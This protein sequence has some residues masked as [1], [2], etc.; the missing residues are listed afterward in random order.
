MRSRLLP[1]P[2]PPAM[3]PMSDQPAIVRALTAVDAAPLRA[4]R[5]E[6]LRAFPPAFAASVEEDEARSIDDFAR[7]L[8][9]PD[10]MAVYGA[11]AG[12]ELVGM[13]GFHRES[14]LKMRHK[15]TLWGVYVRA[16]R[17]GQGLG[18]RLVQAVIDHARGRVERLQ[19]CVSTTNPDAR[20]VYFGLGFKSWGIEERALL[21]DGQW[22]ADEHIVLEL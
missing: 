15:A 19:A 13:A 18:L 8:A 5:L 1:A 12:E 22:H 7:M 21:V 16:D 3:E 9:D 11:F 17:R 20:R 2:I 6:S 4:V 14:R 10:E